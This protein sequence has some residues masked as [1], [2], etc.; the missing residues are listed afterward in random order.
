MSWESPEN[1][2][3]ALFAAPGPDED[4]QQISQDVL[5]MVNSTSEDRPFAVPPV[6][7]SITWRLFVDTAAAPPYDIYP[8]RDGPQPAGELVL[9]YRSMR[10]YVSD[11]PSDESSGTT[12]RRNV[13]R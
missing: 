4:A 2:I 6:A 3:T 8:D 13:V 12:F 7:Q 11:G 10:V 5:L 9:P 1:A